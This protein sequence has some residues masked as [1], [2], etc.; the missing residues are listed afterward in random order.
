[1]PTGPAI[2]SFFFCSIL[3]RVIFFHEGSGC[4]SPSSTLMATGP[5]AS[6]LTISVIQPWSQTMRCHPSHILHGNEGQGKCICALF[7]ALNRIHTWPPALL[8]FQFWLTLLA[9]GHF[10]TQPT[11]CPCRAVV[12]GGYR[13]WSHNFLL[14]KYQWS[15][16]L[17]S[18]LRE[19][20]SRR[21]NEWIHWPK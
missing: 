2:A 5:A 18:V 20:L 10:L 15:Q 19:Q 9:G 7:C 14:T 6:K 21:P 8:E 17:V 13:N 4:A 11:H 3:P 12:W 16:W 1:M